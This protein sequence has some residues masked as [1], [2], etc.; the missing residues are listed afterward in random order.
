[1]NCLITGAASGIGLAVARKLARGSSNAE[2]PVNLALVDLSEDGLKKVSEELMALGAEVEIYAA[3]LSN[4]KAAVEVVESAVSHIGELNA[5]VSNAGIVRHATLLD[6]TTDDFDAAYKVNLRATFLLAKAAHASLKKSKGSIVAT[7]S[8]SGLQPTAG[9]GGYSASKAGLSM[10]VKQM[11]AEWGDDG[12]RCNSVCPGYVVTG[13]TE[14]RYSDAVVTANR[15]SMTSLG[16]I[17][18]AEQIADAICFLMSEEA[19]YISG[20]DL[21]VDGGLSTC[22]MQAAAKL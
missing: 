18:S 9:Y 15:S 5:L 2:E 4:Q 20:V 7:S 11:A 1:M 13:M 10:L 14:K 17:G 16:Y 21:V 19:A 22:L 6:T 12:I 8:I 3:D